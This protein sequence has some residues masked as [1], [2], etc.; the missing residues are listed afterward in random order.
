MPNEALI[1][2][3]KAALSAGLALLPLLPLLALEG[4]AAA[5]PAGSGAVEQCV[6]DHV[7]G[8]EVRLKN[9]LLEARFHFRACAQASCPTVVSK[10]C[11]DFLRELEPRIPSVVPV[12]RDEQ[13]DDVVSGRLL[14]DG[15]AVPTAAWG[16]AREVEPGSHELTFERGGQVIARKTV[17]VVEGEK[18]RAL[19][20]TV[21]APSAAAGADSGSPSSSSPPSDPLRTVGFIGIGLGAAALAGAVVFWSIASSGHADLKSSC[22]PT[23]QQ[24]AL[25]GPQT[26]ALVGD[27]LL[28]SGL[29]LAAAGSFAALW[30]REKASARSGAQPKAVAAPYVLIDGQGASFGVVVRAF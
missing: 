11:S 22:A 9:R 28:G 30:P 12:V 27:I 23:C 29:A 26:K 20:L 2:R 10:A 24:S 5:Q 8:Q 7:A 14:L 1:G 17:T 25:D 13:G 16:L 19:K 6:A 3:R 15:A 18:N 21:P 4:A